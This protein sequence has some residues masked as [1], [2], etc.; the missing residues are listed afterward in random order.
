MKSIFL[1][2]FFSLH[3]EFS[4]RDSIVCLSISNK[5]RS[6]FHSTVAL[7][8]V[9]RHILQ[10]SFSDVCIKGRERRRLAKEKNDVDVWNEWKVCVKNER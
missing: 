2:N 6:I 9:P 8:V 3:M 1:D 5:N 7:F 4:A 10:K